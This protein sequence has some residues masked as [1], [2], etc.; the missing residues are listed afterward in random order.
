M[1]A[2]KPKVPPPPPPPP[3]VA[4]EDPEIRA[5]QEAERRR[6]RQARGRS[7]TIL[8]SALGDAGASRSSAK[9]LLGQ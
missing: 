7:S 5:R 2:S 8:T 6:I 4:A 1:C 9:S 3:P